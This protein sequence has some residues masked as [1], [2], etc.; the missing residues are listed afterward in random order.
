M[1]IFNHV[2]ET[3]IYLEIRRFRIQ[4]HALVL[5]KYLKDCFLICKIELIVASSH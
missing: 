4:L 2:L 1:N 3:Y 5:S